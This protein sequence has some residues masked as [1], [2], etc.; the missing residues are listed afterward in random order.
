M[1]INKSILIFSFLNFSVSFASDIILNDLSTNFN[2]VKSLR[3]YF[4]K[5]SILKSA[6]DAGITILFALVINMIFSY[7]L[8]GFIIPNN[9]IKLIYFCILAFVIGYIIDVLIYKLHI[10]G[11]R[12]DD[13]YKELGAGFWGALAFVFSIVVSYFIQNNL[14][15]ICYKD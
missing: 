13:Y 6:F 2:I 5:Q 11:N 3:S 4:H 8:F 12:L 15:L 14:Y 1:D 9:S 7:Y 10:F